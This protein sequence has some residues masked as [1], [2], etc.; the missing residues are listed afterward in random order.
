VCFPRLEGTSLFES[1]ISLTCV[2][3]CY[4]PGTQDTGLLL[5]EK[6]AEAEP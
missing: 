4:H 3:S 5:N 2:H 6:L 1:E